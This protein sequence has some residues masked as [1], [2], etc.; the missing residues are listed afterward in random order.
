M[1]TKHLTL[2]EAQQAA[3]DYNMS[4]IRVNGI[5]TKAKT[6][7]IVRDFCEAHGYTAEQ[8]E[9]AVRDMLDLL[10]LERNAE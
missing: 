6:V 1:N 9:Y 7:R 10:S 2:T 4:R 8:T 5:R 3:I